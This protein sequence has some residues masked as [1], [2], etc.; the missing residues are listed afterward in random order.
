MLV[1][2]G[3]NGD[4]AIALDAHLQ[5]GADQ[6][7]ACDPHVAGQQAQ[8]GNVDFGFRRPRHN[9]AVAVAHDD[10]ANANRGAAIAGALDLGSA[11]RDVLV[12]AKILFDRGQQATA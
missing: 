12:A 7:E 5:L 3:E 2:A 11:H 9:G 6:I 8:S 4:L 10:V 1:G